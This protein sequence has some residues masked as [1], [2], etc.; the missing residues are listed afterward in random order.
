MVFGAILGKKG[1]HGWSLNCQAHYG[2]PAPDPL[3]T[4][5]ILNEI[6]GFEAGFKPEIKYRPVGQP[7]RILSPTQ[8]D[9]SPNY[10]AGPGEMGN[11]LKNAATH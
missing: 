7:G 6:V 5:G 10:P 2:G 3:P 11:V 8:K 9:F 4:I 1:F